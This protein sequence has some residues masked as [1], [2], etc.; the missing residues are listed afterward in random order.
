MDKDILNKIYSVS[1]MGILGLDEVLDKVNDKSLKK[2]MISAKKNYQAINLKV[3][4]LL[5]EDAKDIN[6]FTHMF[7][8]VYS[9]IKLMNNTDAN[10][11]KMLIEGTNK[12]IIELETLLNQEPEKEIKNIAV[13]LLELLEYQIM[14]WKKYL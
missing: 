9:S 8:E 5:K 10:I 11:V 2:T 12:G 13:E 3:E 7:N 14:S 1:K 4:D 6:M